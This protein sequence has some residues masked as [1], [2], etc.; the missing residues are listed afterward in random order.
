M[1]KTLAIAGIFALSIVPTPSFSGEV[2]VKEINTLSEQLLPQ[3]GE[4]YKK[5]N[6][7]EKKAYKKALNK[8]LKEI[9]KNGATGL[10]EGFSCFQAVKNQGHD[11]TGIDS[12]RMCGGG[13]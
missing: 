12:F 11:S 7:K 9:E 5:L 8:Y 2:E 13:V 10:S 4:K 1:K 3:I 6:K